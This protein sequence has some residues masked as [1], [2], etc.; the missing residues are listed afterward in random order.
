MIPHHPAQAGPRSRPLPDPP[1]H[2]AQAGPRSRPSRI[3]HTTPRCRPSRIPHTAR[4]KP[5]RGAASSP[6]TGE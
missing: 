1:H 4:L 3:P 6:I 2:P 5:G